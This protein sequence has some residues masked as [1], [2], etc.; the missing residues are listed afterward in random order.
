MSKNGIRSIDVSSEDS[1]ASDSGEPTT[2]R[3]SLRTA[4]R[5]GRRPLSDV[6]AESDE[7]G[8]STR[9]VKKRVRLAPTLELKAITPT[10]LT[11]GEA[12]K[13]FFKPRPVH[14]TSSY[15]IPEDIDDADEHDAYLEPAGRALVRLKE[16][17]GAEWLRGVRP[18]DAHALRC[19]REELVDLIS[20]REVCQ[21]PQQERPACEGRAWQEHE[22]RST[23]AVGGEREALSGTAALSTEQQLGAVGPDVAER[24]RRQAAA[25]PSMTT[26]DVGAGIRMAPE[27]L[28]DDLRRAV[29][30]N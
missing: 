9:H 5:S 24:L 3:S 4:L 15:S 16:A 30:S 13:I 1:E 26:G 20:R 19:V 27:T 6:E 29:G 2:P 22:G 7:E 18:K 12:V 14:E 23:P 28:R 8:A 10:S 25:I 21:M 11:A 17:H